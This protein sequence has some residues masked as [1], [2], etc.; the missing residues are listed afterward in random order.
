MGTLKCIRRC[1]EFSPEQNNAGLESISQTVQTL[2]HFQMLVFKNSRWRLAAKMAEF[3]HV[4][5]QIDF[6]CQ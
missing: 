2:Q 3:F 5:W 1:R 4:A 6:Y